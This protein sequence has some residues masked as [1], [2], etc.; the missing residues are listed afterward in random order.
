M[1]AKNSGPNLLKGAMKKDSKKKVLVFPS[2]YPTPEKPVTGSFFREQALLM[3]EDF[4][5]KVIVGFPEPV[6]WGKALFFLLRIKK[7][8]PRSLKVL[9]PPKAVVFRYPQY[10]SR[11]FDKKNLDLMFRHYGNQIEDLIQ[12]DWKPDVLHAHSTWRG[13][14]R[15]QT[16]TEIRNSCDHH[17]TFQSSSASSV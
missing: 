1:T 15:S 5:I 13:H 2:W 9:T 6:F 10:P 7:Y 14:H 11:F 4:D 12:R 17:G 8:A 3:R 16:G